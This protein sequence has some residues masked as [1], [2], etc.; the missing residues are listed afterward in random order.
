MQLHKLYKTA[1]CVTASCTTYMYVHGHEEV[2]GRR[3]GGG[4]GGG[5]GGEPVLSTLGVTT[6]YT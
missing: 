2:G 1:F 3:E 5:G 4:G 6:S